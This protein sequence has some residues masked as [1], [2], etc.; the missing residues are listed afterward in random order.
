MGSYDTLLTNFTEDIKRENERLVASCYGG[1]RSELSGPQEFS[2]A[3]IITNERAVFLNKKYKPEEF[4][5]F[6][7]KEIKNIRLL[8]ER[9]V[10]FEAGAYSITL[11][12]IKY[13]KAGDIAAELSNQL[14][15]IQMEEETTAEEK[16]EFS[17]QVPFA[18]VPFTYND[19]WWYSTWFITVL[20][21]LAVP[22]LFLSGVA[23]IILANVQKN[24]RLTITHHYQE[25]NEELNKRFQE[26]IFQMENEFADKKKLYE[27]DMAQRAGEA[28]ALDRTI[29]SK[30]Q[31]MTK[32][33]DQ[34]N[35]F[36]DQLESL[37]VSK[38]HL[39][40]EHEQLGMKV[41]ELAE[42]ASIAEGYRKLKEEVNLQDVHA[43]ERA[44]DF[45]E[46]DEYRTL[47]HSWKQ[48]Q[49]DMIV[50]DR[51]VMVHEGAF[52]GAEEEDEI[53]A[54]HINMKKMML[55]AFNEECELTITTL[56][57]GQFETATNRI[58][59]AFDQI[60]ML[61]LPFGMELSMDYLDAKI[62]EL[63]ICYEMLE[64]TGEK[65]ILLKEK[66]K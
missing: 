40:E 47:Y 58:H 8:E 32:L 6:D 54:S 65:D 46:A 15:Q 21:I 48:Q 64:A 55:R 60:N 12:D 24:K 39:E 23:A 29:E 26:K 1:C 36:G 7:Y 42:T 30:N 52:A 33:W 9:K 31:E 66:A 50:E 3:F 17:Q 27:R 19:K 10:G 57:K 5:T 49:R 11:R 61:A 38:R 2:G 4:I 16:E 41:M 34:Q 53:P 20:G 44:F 13:A 51:A 18:Y 28:A 25:M 59:K 14:Q 56:V 45:K 43:F 63:N 22:T 37:Q 35:S 62:A